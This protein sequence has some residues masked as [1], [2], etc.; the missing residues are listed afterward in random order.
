MLSHVKI[1]ENYCDAPLPCILQIDDEYFGYDNDPAYPEATF[2]DIKDAHIFKNPSNALSVTTYMSGN[3][4][5]I[6]QY[7]KIKLEGAKT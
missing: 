4:F 5:K 7:S 6:T 1:I 3:R 2:K